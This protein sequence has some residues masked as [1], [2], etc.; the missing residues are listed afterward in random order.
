VAFAF[1]NAGNVAR[2]FVNGVEVAQK[3]QSKDMPNTAAVVRFGRHGYSANYFDGEIDEVRIW[4]YARSAG[5][6]SGDMNHELS[7]TESGLIGYWS[8]NEGSGQVAQDGTTNASHGRLGT[9]TGSDA[10]DPA[11]VNSTVPF[12]PVTPALQLT[13]PNG[14][15]SW[16]VGSAHAIT[17]SSQGSIPSVDLFYSIDNGVNW[18]TMGSSTAN[19]GTENW[20]IPNTIA[21]ECLVRV[22]DAADGDPVDVSNAVF[23]I[24]P[25]PPAPTID[26]FAP[27]SGAVG[28]EVTISGS[29]FTGASVVKFNNVPV[30]TPTVVSDAQ[31][32]AIVPAGATSGKISVT[33]AGGTA[34]SA[35]DFTVTVSSSSTLSFSAAHDAYVRSSSANSSFG[36]AST[37]RVRK[38]SSET[39]NSYLKFDV[40]GVSGTVQSAKLRLYISDAGSDG[41]G[42]YVVSNTYQGS[43]SAWTEGG[44]K[45]S[46]A[47]AISGTALSSAGA[48]SVGN[49]VELDV[50]AGVAGNGT[51]SFAVK[52]NSSDVVYYTSDEGTNRPELVVQYASGPPPTPTISA[53]NPGSGPV[54]TVVTI[55]GTALLGATLVQFNG[56]SAGSITVDSDTQIRAAVP[57]GATTGKVSVTTAGGAVVSTDDFTVTSGGGSVTL[58]IQPLHDAYVKSSSATSN[59]GS[60]STLRGRKSSNET[61]HTYLKFEVAGLGGPVQSA[62]LRLYVTDA[63]S[64]GGSVYAV[65][66]NYLGTST[67][68]VQSGL[69]WNNAPAISGPALGSAGTVSVGSWVEFT[70][71]SAIAGDGTYSLGLTTNASDVV[72]FSSKEGANKPELVIQAGASARA[73]SAEPAPQTAA[74]LFP[75]DF[76]VSQNYPNPFN[77]ETTIEYTLPEPATVQLVIF[78]SL[79]Q[80]VRELVDEYQPV[81]YHHV[82]WNGANAAG[83]RV[84]SGIYFYRLQA[85]QRSLTGKMIL[86]Q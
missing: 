37:L 43:S 84:G 23:A 21:S 80:R 61:L 47:P 1:D 27:G 12:G 17:W 3:S 44:L 11:W 39:L 68:W 18:T 65:S 51:Y 41:G 81:G 55:N 38:S 13:S 67:A 36:S 31:V 54:G 60:A 25:P 74:A 86:Q 6:L 14:G 50:S 72:Y 69:N 77:A 19:D 7:G 45:W 34:T 40:A 32:R 5:Q 10:G 79:G 52:N 82:V 57:S 66:N 58:T 29:H 15:E 48:V 46:N 85:G 83:E 33:T 75:D 35:D 42:V 22:S 30:V 4:N 73:A 8:F 63:S 20:T 2:L 56:T 71:T 59:F 62:T 78:N 24:I 9:T 64:D 16:E 26:S 28:T 70:V 53:F 76:R 49:W